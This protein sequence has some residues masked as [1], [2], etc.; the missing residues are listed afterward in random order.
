M[1]QE[2]SK[3]VKLNFSISTPNAVKTL[4]V[5]GDVFYFQDETISKINL[6]KIHIMYPEGSILFDGCG[7]E[8]LLDED[9]YFEIIKLLSKDKGS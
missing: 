4:Q 8:Q 7:S 9:E 2:N 1:L 6:N 5:E 3:S